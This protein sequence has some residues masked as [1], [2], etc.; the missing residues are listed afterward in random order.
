MWCWRWPT[1]TA[2]TAAVHRAGA[3]SRTSSISCM[4]IKHTKTPIGQATTRA[5]SV[6]AAVRSGPRHDHEQ[7]HGRPTRPA[8]S[9]IGGDITISRSAPATATAQHA[10]LQV[11]RKASTASPTRVYIITIAVREVQTDGTFGDVDHRLRQSQTAADDAGCWSTNRP[12]PASVI[13][14]AFDD[15]GNA[16]C[17]SAARRRSPAISATSICSPAPSTARASDGTTAR[18]S[19]SPN[20]QLRRPAEGAGSSAAGKPRTIPNG[21]VTNTVD[22]GR[23]RDLEKQYAGG[24]RAVAGPARSKASRCTSTAAR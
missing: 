23:F 19:T 5:R 21:V 2:P 1:P 11:R 10:T 24:A 20:A 14:G 8:S 7:R 15:D 3:G 12:A 9:R 13:G 18:S 16:P 22:T 17:R 6:F 4:I